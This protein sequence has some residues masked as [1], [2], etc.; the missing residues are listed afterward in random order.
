LGDDALDLSS[1]A[2]LRSLRVEHGF[3]LEELL[4]HLVIMDD[5]RVFEHRLE[6]LRSSRAGHDDA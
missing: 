1:A 6:L 5:E 3:R 2:G 4:E